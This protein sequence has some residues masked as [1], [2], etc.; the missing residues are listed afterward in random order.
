[1]TRDT[2]YMML[3]RGRQNPSG[4]QWMESDLI[5]VFAITPRGNGRLTS[6][7]ASMVHRSD[8]MHC[9]SI[10]TTHSGLERRMRD[11]T[12]STMEWQITLEAPMDCQAI[13]LVPFMKI[14]RATFGW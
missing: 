9:S 8:L 10:E 5:W 12:V 6:F 11:S 3:W 4:Q 14:T 7:P 1:M 13:L 2:T